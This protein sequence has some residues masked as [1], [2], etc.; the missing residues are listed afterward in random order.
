MGITNLLV[1]IALAVSVGAIW[2]WYRIAMLKKRVAI[3]E[4]STGIQTIL[5]EVL[6][7]AKGL[8]RIVR[9]AMDNSTAES[10]SSEEIKKISQE[11]S[12]VM[13]ALASRI[14]WLQSQDIEDP[15]VLDEYKFYAQ[16]VREK[17]R[18]LSPMIKSL[19]ALQDMK[20]G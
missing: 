5:L 13:K 15:V 9:F 16:E 11:L 7:E 2:N 1:L 19:E 20:K 14:T 10:A 18:K 8:Y 6:L 12:Q 3:A 17:L 4:K